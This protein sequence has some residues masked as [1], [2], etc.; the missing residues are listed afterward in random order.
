[1]SV[2]ILDVT[3]GLRLLP[4]FVEFGFHVFGPHLVAWPLPPQQANEQLFG[5]IK[6]GLVSGLITE[7]CLPVDCDL[8]L[9]AVSCRGD[10]GYFF[11]LNECCTSPR[12]LSRAVALGVV[13]LCFL[14]QS[15]KLFRSVRY[16]LLNTRSR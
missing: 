3:F 4:E 14:L 2:S 15:N 13:E 1:M 6:I 16:L 12:Y 9:L 8:F 11:S 10:C 5:H 7:S